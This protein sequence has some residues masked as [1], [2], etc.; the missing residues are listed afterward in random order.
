MQRIASG[1]R[2]GLVLL[3]LWFIV[4]A[5]PVKADVGPKPDMTFTFDFQGE[6]LTIS[7][8]DQLECEKSDCSDGVALIE[9]GPQRFTCAETGCRSLAYSYKDYHKLVLQFSD[10]STRESNV[11]GKRG[12]SAHYKVTV[13]AD[14]LDVQEDTLPVDPLGCCN[15]ALG[16]VAVEVVVAALALSLFHL[17]RFLTG[18]AALGSLLTLPFVWLVFP[19]LPV[20]PA[21]STALAEG[22]AVLAEAGLFHLASGRSLSWRQALLLSLATNGAS[23]VFG[24]VI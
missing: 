19:L 10:G 24:L 8:G 23:F 22:F 4:P 6:A 17:P 2:A 14:S 1:L 18:W 12:F 7:G 13:K 11:F 3:I 21:L 9:G 15:G 5:A 16:T 20:P